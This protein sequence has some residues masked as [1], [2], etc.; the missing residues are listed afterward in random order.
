MS[1]RA[2]YLL[3]HS[4]CIVYCDGSIAERK[5]ERKEERKNTEIV[6]TSLSSES[7]DDRIY[8]GVIKTYSIHYTLYRHV[9]SQL[10]ESFQ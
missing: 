8:P 10:I 9:L 7:F 2:K 4:N 5:E 6:I 3:P 1:E